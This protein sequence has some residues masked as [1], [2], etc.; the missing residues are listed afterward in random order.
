[1]NIVC[2]HCAATNR[3]AEDKPLKQGKCG[4]CKEALFSGQIQTLTSTTF[5][6]AISDNSIPVLVDFWADWC[7][8][9]KMMAPI[10]AECCR[11]LEPQIRF[12]KVDTQAEQQIA[13]NLGIQSIPTLILY[14][15]SKVLERTSGVM[16]KEQLIQWLNP[17]LK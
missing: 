1:M 13:L 3:I 9:C 16:P 4:R 7:Q 2:P 10:F 12:A 17:Y 6:K 5:S 11:E 8:P 14:Q 15:E